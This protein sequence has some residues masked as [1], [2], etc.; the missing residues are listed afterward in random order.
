MPVTTAG[1]L[2]HQLCLSSLKSQHQQQNCTPALNCSNA[3]ATAAWEEAEQMINT[4]TPMTTSKQ[5]AHNMHQSSATVPEVI[6]PF[7]K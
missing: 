1:A 6:D 2:R 5:Q 4:H 3:Q 7:R